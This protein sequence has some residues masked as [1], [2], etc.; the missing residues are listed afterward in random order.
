LLGASSEK[1]E[2]RFWIFDLRCL[3]ETWQGEIAGKPRT[4]AGDDR[5]ARFVQY[6]L[7]NGG[8]EGGSERTVTAT[9]KK[10]RKRKK[11]QRVSG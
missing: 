11:T 10:R 1:G 2:V 5:Q 9:I 6:Y 8:N 3:H 7:A 4:V